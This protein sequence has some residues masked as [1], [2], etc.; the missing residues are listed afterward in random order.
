VRHLT[1]S[2]GSFTS[3][4][5]ALP[6]QILNLFNAALGPLLNSLT[7]FLTSL[8]TQ[9]AGFLVPIL[10]VVFISVFI[11]VIELVVTFLLISSALHA[12]GI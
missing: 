3:T 5:A 7:G 8:I 11:L 12:F 2:A 6:G 1:A 4:A 10:I 9:L